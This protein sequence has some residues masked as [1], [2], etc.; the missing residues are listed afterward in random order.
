MMNDDGHDGKVIESS[1][2]TVAALSHDSGGPQV[3]ATETLPWSAK[4]RP[5]T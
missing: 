1:L 5:R 4:V 3:I 2:G